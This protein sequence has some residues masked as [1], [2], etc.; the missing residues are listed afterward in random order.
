MAVVWRARDTRLGRTVALKVLHEHVAARDENRERFEREAKAVARLEH[1]NIVRIYAVSPP[2]ASRQYIATELIDGPTL[3]TFVEQ[4]GFCLPEVARLAGILVG[5]AL[6]HAHESKVI[7]RDVKPENI[8]LTRDGGLRLMDFGLARVLDTQK[9]TQ[10]GAILG[11]PAHMSPELIDGGDIDEGADIFAFGTVLYFAATRRLPFDGRNPAVILNAI[12]TGDYTAPSRVNPRVSPELEAVIARCLRTRRADRYATMAEV[13]AA[14][15]AAVA[16]FGFGA[17]EIELRE[18]LADPD[19][20]RA[21][22]ESRV[23]DVLVAQAAERAAAGRLAPAAALCDRALAIAPDHPGAAALLERLAAGRQRERRR[24]LAAGALAGAALIGA[25][26]LLVRLVPA[27]AEPAEPVPVA[28][29][30][31]LAEL[32]GAAQT[33]GE[34]APPGPAADA[35]ADAIAVAAQAVAAA[36]AGSGASVDGSGAA[37]EGSAPETSPADALALEPVVRPAVSLRRETVAALADA[38]RDAPA[39]PVATP[40]P[41]LVDARVVVLPGAAFVRIDGRDMGQAGDL[42]RRTLR[43]TPG[44]HRIEAAVEGLRGAEIDEFFDVGPDGADLRFRIPW[45]P[46]E[47]VVNGPRGG[48]VVIDGR[49]AG[50]TGAR[51]AV[52]N[53]SAD[54]AFEVRVAV[55]PRG[56][57]SPTVRDVELRSGQLATVE[58]GGR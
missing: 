32:G 12:L 22:A 44:R 36:S 51:I 43:L 41:V 50:E 54:P 58:L 15:E 8:M 14:L 46:A 27:P 2:A 9:L 52:P 39:P 1:P 11:S 42:A 10:T 3:R 57:G 31:A 16:P 37:T 24:R 13:V 6:A 34:E 56:G 48:T 38:G 21:R 40:E 45:P 19:A 30:V 26:A 55:V 17:P 33:P 29:P 49:V 28:E 5:R 53:E 18:L 20:Y 23:A 47:L 25:L 35:P 7:H 4:T